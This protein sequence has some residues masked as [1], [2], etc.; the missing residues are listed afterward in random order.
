V[1][2]FHPFAPAVSPISFRA[3]THFLPRIRKQGLWICLPR[4]ELRVSFSTRPFRVE[5][6]SA[7]VEVV[8]VNSQGAIRRSGAL[9]GHTRSPRAG[10]EADHSGAKALCASTKPRLLSAE[11]VRHIV[12]AVDRMP[13]ARYLWYEGDGRRAKMELRGSEAPGRW[14]R[15]RG[16]DCGS[17]DGGT[18]LPRADTLSHLRKRPVLSRQT[19]KL[20]LGHERYLPRG[21]LK[22]ARCPDDRACLRSKVELFHHDRLQPAQPGD[23][24]T[25]A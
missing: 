3:S 8:R 4:K 12:E 17:A 24:P 19:L 21:H 25:S 20:R 16:A 7:T 10:A 6:E 2:G 14:R 11:F 23:I 13:D 15:R 9:S 5:G 22:T 1:T 18:F